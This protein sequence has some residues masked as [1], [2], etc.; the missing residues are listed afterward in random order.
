MED[1][2][3]HLTHVQSELPDPAPPEDVGA[4]NQFFINAAKQSKPAPNPADIRHILSNKSK[5]ST[6]P[7]PMASEEMIVNGKTFQQVHLHTYSVSASK[8]SSTQSLVDR[9]ANGGIGGSDV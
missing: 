8:S 6:S 9:G 5:M 2:D 7:A 3:G 4:S 1:M